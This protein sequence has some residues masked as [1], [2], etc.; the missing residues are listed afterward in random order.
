MLPGVAPESL[1]V[2]FGRAF[3]VALEKRDRDTAMIF[4]RAL[5]TQFA[6]ASQRL[7]RGLRS[8][9]ISAVTSSALRAASTVTNLG[10]LAS[11]R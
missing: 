1:S 5:L 9:T 3:L 4:A 7:E 6:T 2:V 8:S 10:S 11:W